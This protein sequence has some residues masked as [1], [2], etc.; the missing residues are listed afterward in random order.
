MLSRRRRER[1]ER[2]AVAVEAALV[3]PILVALVF[4][5]VE[6]GMYFKDSLAVSN[7]VRAGVRI[8]SAEPRIEHF[9][10]DAADSVAREATALSMGDVAELWVYQADDA[11]IPVGDTGRFQSCT[12]CVKYSWDA[13][14]GSF[15][16]ISDTWPHTAHNA[17]IPE[18][19]GT[20]RR[21]SIG[22]YLRYRHESTTH[23]FM[24]EMEIRDHAV[25]KFEPIPVAKVCA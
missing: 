15:R 3:M 13:G 10:T 12:S 11:G 6:F 2:G 23:L 20:D 1:R 19:G 21:M 8:A 4:G 22:V 14:A 7:A 24:D 25:M 16:E 18:E 17:C 5:I 9:A